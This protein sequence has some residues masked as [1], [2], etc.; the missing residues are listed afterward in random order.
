MFYSKSAT[1]ERIETYIKGYD[2]LGDSIMTDL[3]FSSPDVLRRTYNGSPVSLARVCKL[4]PKKRSS[5]LSKRSRWTDKEDA[6]LVKAVAKLV[7]PIDYEKSSK[8]TLRSVYTNVSMVLG[9]TRRAVELRA[10]FLGLRKRTA[11]SLSFTAKNGSVRSGKTG[12]II[13]PAYVKPTTIDLT[14]SKKRSPKNQ[15][16]IQTINLG[17][18]VRNVSILYTDAGEMQVKFEGK[19][20][21]MEF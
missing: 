12:Q 6:L 13:K 7:D 1:F 4:V 8:H 14:K 15:S 3:G 2:A 9:R 10:T 16:G 21:W 5:E 19:Q 20:I 11:D 18:N 17:K